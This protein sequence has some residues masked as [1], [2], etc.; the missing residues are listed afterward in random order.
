MFGRQEVMLTRRKYQPVGM[1]AALL[2]VDCWLAGRHLDG[3]FL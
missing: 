1:M 3:R 2:L